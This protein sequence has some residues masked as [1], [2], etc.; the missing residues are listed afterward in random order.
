MQ[1]NEQK[2]YYGCFNLADDG[3]GDGFLTL[4]EELLEEMGWDEST[5]L[6]T[7]V[8][9]GKTGNVLVI[10]RCDRVDNGIEV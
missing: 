8:K 2:Q 9:M 1:C 7:T 6:S 5:I 3:S 10:R 4:P